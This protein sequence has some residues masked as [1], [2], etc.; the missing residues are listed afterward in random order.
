[1]NQSQQI[2]ARPSGLPCQ[3]DLLAAAYPS[4]SRAASF[5]FA[6]PLGLP[7]AA[8]RFRPALPR[9]Y[10]LVLSRPLGLPSAA[11]R[12]RPALP[13]LYLLVL[14][15]P[16][17]VPATTPLTPSRVAS[18]VF[19]RLVSS[20]WPA[21]CCLQVPS[22]VASF[23]FA[24]LVSSSWRSC[25]YPPYSVPCCLSRPSVNLARS[26]L[27][28]LISFN[29][30]RSLDFGEIARLCQAAC[31]SPS[32]RRSGLRRGVARNRMRTEAGKM[33][34]SLIFLTENS[35]GV[36]NDRFGFILSRSPGYANHCFSF[37]SFLFC[38]VL[39]LRLPRSVCPKAA[40]SKSLE[41]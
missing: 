20:S 32:R 41:R 24:R 40:A 29:P 10:L 14:S 13:R 5:V 22:R 27:F 35:P 11:F 3:I 21:F 19:A 18:F 16:L 8:F 37:M 28:C 6:R 36:S 26:A 1:M 38:P 7:S 23:V 15:R 25:Y 30:N 31:F 4:P 9:L 2:A 33:P 17:G 12:F 39:T 34:E